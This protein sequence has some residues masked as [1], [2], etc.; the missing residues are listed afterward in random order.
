MAKR[1]AIIRRLVAFEAL[2]CTTVVCTDKT[3]TLT[4]NKM[5]VSLIMIGNTSGGREVLLEKSTPLTQSLFQRC[6]FFASEISFTSEEIT[7]HSPIEKALFSL[8]ETIP[9]TQKKEQRTILLPFESQSQRMVSKTTCDNE[10]ILWCKGSPERVSQMCSKQLMPD[11]TVKEFESARF[12]RSI[13]TFASEGFR[14]IALAYRSDDTENLD[15]NFTLI[16]AIGLIDPPREE[17]KEAIASCQK[18]GIRVYMI[19][20]D[21]PKTAQAVARE[22]DFAHGQTEVLLGSTIDTLND[23]QLTNKLKTHSIIA[24][25]SPIH[26]LR[27]VSLLQKEGH[28]VAMT[29]D[30]VND[31][32]PLKQ[33]DIGIAMGSGTDAA[34]AAGFLPGPDLAHFDS[35]FE[36]LCQEFYQFAEIDPVFSRIIKNSLCAISLNLNIVD[37]HR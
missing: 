22:V 1:K 26:K 23:E 19:T 4:Q 32:P 13:E 7:M 28:I 5:S 33:A 3:G 15:S 35:N 31:T 18:A 24:R 8:V 29:G 10:T 25:A 16:G 20:G 30:G 21:H 17:A 37:L 2:G 11:G 6:A 14:T 12:L 27:I 34:K 36:F 9:F